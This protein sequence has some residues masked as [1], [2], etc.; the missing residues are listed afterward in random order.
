MKR[1]SLVQMKAGQKGKIAEIAGGP[2]LR[3][4]LMSMGIYEGRG[5]AKLSHFALKGPVAVRV[6]RSTLALGHGMAVKIIVEAE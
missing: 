6:G 4:R 5:I 2:A 3:S 1:M